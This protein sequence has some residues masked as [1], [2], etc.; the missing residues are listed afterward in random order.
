MAKKKAKTQ[1]PTA[2]DLP[3]NPEFQEF[4]DFT[5]RLMRVPKSDVGGRDREHSGD[6]HEREDDR[7]QTED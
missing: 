7:E 5:R 6:D 2:A 1:N 4:A 3:Q